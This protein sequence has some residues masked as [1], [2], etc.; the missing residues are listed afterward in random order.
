MTI[1][2]P[3]LVTS[4][5]FRAMAVFG[6]ASQTVVISPA[7]HDSIDHC[8]A[9]LERHGRCRRIPF[10]RVRHEMVSVTNLPLARVEGIAAF[11]VHVRDVAVTQL[12]AFACLGE[13][14]GKFAARVQFV[15]NRY[16]I[17]VKR[18]LEKLEIVLGRS[19]LR[20]AD[21]GLIAHMPTPLR[22][23]MMATTT[24]IDQTK[25]RFPHSRPLSARDFTA[26]F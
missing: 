6:E 10:S 13:S 21:I 19:V 8:L 23:P 20:L 2:A 17:L 7:I 1:G 26:F 3:L 12:K 9:T 4:L 15:G 11:E 18:T 16:D 22:I 24:R 5:S 14:L 25:A